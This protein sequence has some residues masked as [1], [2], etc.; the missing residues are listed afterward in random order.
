M[1][2]L[3]KKMADACGSDALAEAREDAAR[4][5]DEFLVHMAGDK[6]SYL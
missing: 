4:D 3:R 2:G 5:K 6:G 1:A